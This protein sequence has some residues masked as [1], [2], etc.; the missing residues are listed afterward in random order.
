MRFFSDLSI[1]TRLLLIFILLH[2]CAMMAGAQQNPL[3]PG[4]LGLHFTLHQFERNEGSGPHTGLALSYLRGIR[5]R[6]DYII[7]LNGSFPDSASAR[8]RGA[9]A[10]SLLLQADAVLRL[11][12]QRSPQKLSPHL[13][14]GG[15]ISQYRSAA[16]LYALAGAG[17]SF[18]IR[19]V[20][21]TTTAQYRY[22]PTDRLYSH[23]HYSIGIAGLLA[24]KARKV[25]SPP[26]SAPSAGGDRDG[27]GI[28]DVND[29][30]P[31]A[32]GLVRFRGCPDSDGDGIE[33]SLD[34]CVLVPGVERYA[35]CPVPDLDRDGIDDEQDSCVNRPGVMRYH[36]CPVPDTDG[37][38]VNDEADS[39]ATIA[40]S[41][42]NK[43]CPPP[44]TALDKKLALFAR[45]VYF[46]TGSYR[47][48]P[49]SYPALDELAALLL[50][51]PGLQLRIEGHTDNQGKAEANQLLSERRAAAVRQYLEVKG[52]LP[53]RLESAGY[54]STRPVASNASA[55]G[56]AEN[57]RVAFV[58]R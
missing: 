16:G 27:D 10:K 37:D 58:V 50:A 25:S 17:L 5:P 28:V 47:L 48:L 51:Q 2:G 24:R 35:G 8:R 53:T 56:R 21:I 36:G 44:D 9:D 39:C 3:H 19:D 33:D 13:L 49:S 7:S 29:R 4:V 20:F 26:L 38:G 40:G 11:R 41:T 23:F 42:A 46:A 14:A 45:Q 32:P 43:G 31:D 22:G 54:G 6:L 30:C 15:G 52:I 57:R 34:R 18:S 12:M 1:M 55:E